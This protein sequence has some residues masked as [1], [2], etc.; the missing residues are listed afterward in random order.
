LQKIPLPWPREENST[1]VWAIN[2]F[3]M[4]QDFKV[5]AD[6]KIGLLIAEFV[7]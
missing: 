3:S 4:N 2:F 6:L 5:L 1:E 7:A